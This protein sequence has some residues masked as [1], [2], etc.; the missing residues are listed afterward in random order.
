MSEKVIIK[1]HITK[2]DK[3]SVQHFGEILS[4]DWFEA[5]G[6]FEISD[7]YHTFEELYDHRITLFIAL[8]KIENAFEKF[9]VRRDNVPLFNSNYQIVSNV[10]RSKINGDGT[11]WDGWFIMGIG[12]IAGQQIT[13]HLPLDRWEE[14][15]F[16]ETLDKAPEWD[17]HSPADVL[18]RL[19]K[20]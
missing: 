6:Q 12:K 11:R 10:W 4:R 16:A 14:T 5:E 8:C 7:G 17:G 3:E 13:Y 2:A 20:L 1:G 15:N 19:K 18:D 9:G